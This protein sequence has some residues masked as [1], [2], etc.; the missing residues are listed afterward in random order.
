VNANLGPDDTDYEKADVR[1][2]IIRIALFHYRQEYQIGETARRK[3]RHSY[4]HRA[5]IHRLPLLR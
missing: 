3:P 5:I 4:N 2:E 1:N